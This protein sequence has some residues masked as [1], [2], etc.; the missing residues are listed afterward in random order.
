MDIS[1]Q[2]HILPIVAILIMATIG[3]E[4]RLAQFDV[5]FKMRGVRAKL[6][7]G[8][9]SYSPPKLDKIGHF[10]FPTYTIGKSL[11]K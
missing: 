7:S 8:V 10:Q 5:L 2:Q 6:V 1:V 9:K 4:L 11:P 3:M